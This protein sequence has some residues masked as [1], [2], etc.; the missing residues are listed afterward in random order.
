MESLQAKQNKIRAL[1]DEV[2]QLHPV[3]K[4]L[5]P[6]LPNISNVAYTHGQ[7]EMGAD[8]VI[9]RI[10][11]TLGRE[12]YIGVIVKC[13]DIRQ[14]FDDVER[15]IKEC[16]VPR[17]VDGGKKNI[18]LN[19]I[20]VVTNGG[21]SNNAKEK[22]HQ[23]YNDKNI[24]FIWD[25]T[26]IELL[27]KHFPEYWENVDRNIGLYLSSVGRRLQDLNAKYSLAEMADSGDFYIEQEV[28]RINLE[29]Q[30]KFRVSKTNKP[31]KLA[32]V[33][34]Q[35]RFVMVEAG[36]GYG[37]SRL[38]R[39]AA[40]DLAVN[41][42]FADHGI[43]PVFVNF[44]DLI[45]VHECSLGNLLENLRTVERI[46]PEEHSILFVIDSVAVVSG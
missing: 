9:T 14:N 3:L 44:R 5:F 20:W 30:K 1:V 26:L 34:S 22:I 38:L 40:I 43:L 32:E 6:K 33:L 35:E 2:K 21:I 19:D 7:S 10:D 29:A 25:E 12:E 15:Q 28:V 27:N 41:R 18:Y 16:S 36:M 17:K 24:A 11:Q 23:T 37:K 39:Q 13:G 31:E 8:F 4:D 45:E 46:D 42:K